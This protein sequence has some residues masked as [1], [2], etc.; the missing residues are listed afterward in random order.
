MRINDRG[1]NKAK[2]RSKKHHKSKNGMRVTNRSIFILEEQ[3]KKKAKKIKE[4]RND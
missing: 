2:Q 1:L 3:K 4:K